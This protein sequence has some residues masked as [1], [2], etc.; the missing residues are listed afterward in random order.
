MN[1]EDSLFAGA[2]AEQL[3]GRP[4]QA[5]PREAA[6]RELDGACVLVT[7]A[8][9]SLG[10]ALLA[11]LAQLP[12]E[13]IVAIDH[14]EASL[15][16]VGRDLAAKAPIELRLADIRNREKL[17]R[18]FTEARPTIIFHFAA[19]K[20]VP[21]AEYGPDEFVEV[22]VLGTE[23]VIVAA[24]SAGARHLLYP[25]SDKAVNP[26]SA[27]GATKRIAET[28]LIA[29]GHAHPGLLTHVV[30]YVNV[31]GSS[32]SFSETCA[33]QA[34]A[35][36]PVTLTDEQMLR[37]WMTTSE[38]VDLLSHGLGLPSGSRTVLDTGEPI[39]VKTIAERIY[40]AASPDGALPR[41]VLTGARPGERL[42]EE[43]ASANERLGRHGDDPVLRLENA[44]AA[45]Q[46][47]QIGAAVDELRSILAD[48]DYPRLHRQLM[49]IA[50]QLQ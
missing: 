22:N 27:Y 40:R 21:F 48:G 24:A 16:R 3:L 32:G 20:H 19:Y 2:S 39:P 29:A 34:R 28:M 35:G 50:Q 7:G 41:F 45:Q 5:I 42:A 38:A 44:C 17:Q 33:Q 1:G 8:G 18:I 47:A 12:V 15:F 23:S 31:L 43:L 25:S 14:H 11:R 37:Y 46:E 4:L 36:L 9:G 10:T 49:A 26:P 30:R 13:R 6:L